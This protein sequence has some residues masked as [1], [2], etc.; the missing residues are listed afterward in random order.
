MHCGAETLRP[1]W[2]F[3]GEVDLAKKI[4][5]CLVSRQSFLF[6]SC[7]KYGWIFQ[8]FKKCCLDTED[9]PKS[10]SICSNLQ[11]K[12]LSLRSQHCLHWLPVPGFAQFFTHLPPFN[13]YK[14]SRIYY[15]L[16]NYNPGCKLFVQIDQGERFNVLLFHLPSKALL[17]SLHSG[18]HSAT[19]VRNLDSWS[20]SHHSFQTLGGGTCLI[21][22]RWC[23]N[24]VSETV[25]FLLQ[26]FGRRR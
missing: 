19:S 14:R 15:N 1:S 12:S 23:A 20:R 24:A 22:V 17:E 26:F 16:A 3:S 2:G 11:V 10:T 5:S 6:F 8:V 4:A 7:Q 21:F 25:P 18:S 9:S 13:H